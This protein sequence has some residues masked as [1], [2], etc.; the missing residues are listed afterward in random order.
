MANTALAPVSRSVRL[1]SGNTGRGPNSS[2]RICGSHP[3]QNVNA[4]AKPLFA[5]VRQTYVKRLPWIHGHQ[6]HRIIKLLL[7]VVEQLLRDA[8]IQPK[9]IF[10]P[11][12]AHSTEQRIADHLSVLRVEAFARQPRLNE[13]CQHQDPHDPEIESQKQGA[14]L[15][16]HKNIA[17]TTNGLE[18]AWEWPDHRPAYDAGV[19]P[20][21]RW[22]GP[23]RH[24]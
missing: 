24:N 19:T 2:V 16:I 14:S 12:V 18:S 4:I 7:N 9:A 13:T 17:N 8:V 6:R 15:V 3:R 11:R 21:D 10:I 5:S 23:G 1:G 22:T 20:A